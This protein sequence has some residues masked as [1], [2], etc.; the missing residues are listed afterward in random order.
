MNSGENHPRFFLCRASSYFLGRFKK[1]ANEFVVKP[2]PIIGTTE[3]ISQPSFPKSFNHSKSDLIFSFFQ[4]PSNAG[5]FCPDAF[6]FSRAICSA[7]VIYSQFINHQLTLVLLNITPII[8]RPI[9]SPAFFLPSRVVC[10]L[11]PSPRWGV[12]SRDLM[13]NPTPSSPEKTL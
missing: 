11:K 2:T 9:A 6:S 10:R 8:F 4:K 12:F 5:F 3:T 1:Y 7:S 13:P